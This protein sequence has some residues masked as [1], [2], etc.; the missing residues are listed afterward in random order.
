VWNIGVLARA[1][2]DDHYCFEE[3]IWQVYLKSVFSQPNE[4][5]LQN[6][7]VLVLIFDVDLQIVNVGKD[8]GKVE[9]DDL[10]QPLI[11]SGHP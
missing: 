5:L 11:Q 3:G 8:V 7:L 4:E 1:Q 10:H 2:V 6:I 9:N